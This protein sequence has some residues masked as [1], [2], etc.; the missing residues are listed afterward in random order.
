MNKLYFDTEQQARDARTPIC[1]C[2]VKVWDK[3]TTSVFSAEFE[4]KHYSSLSR[5][6]V[7]ELPPMVETRSNIKET[8]NKP[9]IRIKDFFVF[10]KQIILKKLIK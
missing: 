1:Q 10:S 4:R 9:M 3:Y 2:V 7:S 8:T 5:Q 6:V